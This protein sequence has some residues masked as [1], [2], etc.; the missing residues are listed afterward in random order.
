MSQGESQSLEGFGKMLETRGIAKRHSIVNS[1][2][3][4][5]ISPRGRTQITLK[6]ISVNKI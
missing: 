1:C 6:K 4:S 2:R 5:C 3:F